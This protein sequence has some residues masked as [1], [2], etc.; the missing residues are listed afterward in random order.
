MSDA[1][2][3]RETAQ[4]RTS[5]IYRIAELIVRYSTEPAGK[6]FKVRDRESGEL[7]PADY[8][9]EGMAKA[10]ARLHA[11]CDIAALFDLPVG[12]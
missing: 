8:A 4:A 5:R 2:A 3:P 11:A 12:R 10:G 7:L 9:E 1:A 6:A